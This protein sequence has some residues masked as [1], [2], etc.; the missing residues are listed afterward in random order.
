MNGVSFHRAQDSDCPWNE[1][2]KQWKARIT[3]L[4]FYL[5]KK[6]TF[7]HKHTH[8]HNCMY[9]VLSPEAHILFCLSASQYYF[10]CIAAALKYV[11]LLQ[12]DY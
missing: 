5:K 1:V 8:K 10:S 3:W 9:F 11:K 4:L 7:T 6:Q 12:A 2:E